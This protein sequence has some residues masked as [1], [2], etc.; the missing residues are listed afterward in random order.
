[1]ELFEYN[2]KFVL[3]SGIILP[4]IKITYHAYGRLNAAKVNVVWV[5][6]ALS[7][8]SDVVDWWKGAIGKGCII[9]PDE[10]FIV[11]TKQI[12]KYLGDWLRNGINTGSRI[13]SNL[14]Y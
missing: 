11:E 2:H 7:A 9:N 12:I 8:N 10:H 6:H 13:L 4:E 14:Q 5:C 1:M 3:E